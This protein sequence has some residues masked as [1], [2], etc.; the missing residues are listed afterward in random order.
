M[1]YTDEEMRIFSFHD[2]YEER[3]ADP[4]ELLGK[5]EQTLGEIGPDLLEK[6]QAN[7]NQAG[8]DLVGKLRPVFDLKP[9]GKGPDG[10]PE[11][12]PVARVLAIFLEFLEFNKTLGEAVGPSVTSLSNSEQQPLAPSTTEHSAGSTSTETA[13]SVAAP[14][15]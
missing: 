4:L 2:G 9:V 7:D 10:K 14:S 6:V 5:L 1:A 3:F 11:G 12:T 8:L 15:Q 13:P